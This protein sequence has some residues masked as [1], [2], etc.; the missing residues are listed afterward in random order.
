MRIL[1]A[2]VLAVLAAV[3]LLSAAT[4][5]S[6]QAENEAVSVPGSAPAAATPVDPTIQTLPLSGVATGD[7]QSSPAPE[8][9]RGA[10]GAMALRA[11]SS[12]AVLTARSTTSAFQT[13]GVTWADRDVHPD[14]LIAVRTHASSGWSPWQDLDD[15]AGDD[16]A[17]AATAGGVRGGTDPLWVG[18][19]DGVQARILVTSGAL[20][21]DLKLELVDGGRS[22][23]DAVAASTS[24]GS[25]AAQPG[26]QSGALSA[27]GTLSAS[28]VTEP[29][30]LGRAQWGADD[31]KIKCPATYMPTIKAAV[32]HHTAGKN[33]YS[34]AQVPSI[35]RGDYAYHLSRGWCDIGYNALVDRFG[36]IWEGRAGGLTRAVMGAHAGGFNTDTFGV[37]VI[38]NYDVSRPTPA[39]VQAVARV[40]AWKLDLY[41][42]DPLGTTTLTSA[43]GGTAR[44]KA[45]TTVTLPVIMG[46]RNTGATACPGRYLYPYLPAIR[47]QV[48]ALTKAALMNP[49]GPPAIVKRGTT[50]KITA[51]ALTAQTWRLDVS[52]PCGGGRV[53]RIDGSVK[54]R[55]EITATW[56]G[57]LADGRAARP[58]RYTFTLTSS[59]S[60][61]AARPVSY[62]ALVLPPAP[63][64]EI[65]AAPLVGVGSYL[66]VTP[67][68][69]LDTRAAGQ[70][71]IG[72]AGRIDVP[73]LGRAGVPSS[74]VTAVVLNLTASCGS[75]DTALSVWPSGRAS[76]RPVTS[77]PAG[78]TR[79]VLVTS[80]VGADG[81]IS[82]GNAR[83]VSE[84]TADIVGYYTAAGGWPVQAI[85]SV[86]LYDSSSDPAGKLIADAPRLIP[87]PAQ[88]AGVP[89]AQIKAVVLDVT[90][91]SPAG[92]GTLA[93]YQPGAAGDL[94]SLSYRKGESIDN[95]AIAPVS[96]GSIALKATGTPV[97]ALL[98]VRA[99]IVDPSLAGTSLTALKPALVLDTGVH[100]PVKAGA[101]RKVVLT[102]T[103]TGVPAGARAV[104]IDLTALDPS[105]TTALQVYPWGS[106][107]P[108]GAA[109]RLAA[110]DVRGNLVIVPLGADGAI[111]VS[112]ARGST[113]TRV[114]VHGYLG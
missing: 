79:S 32:M 4:M 96:G 40:M 17:V 44:W 61:G 46:H 39:A 64:P 33:N 85:G 83:G 81:S 63:A 11:L 97:D 98:D 10:P 15:D 105:T 71:G 73:V 67:T 34:A 21:K 78:V 19:S 8:P 31:S 103:A 110:G 99:L 45:G 30:V 111:A 48:Q 62:H 43:G 77:V 1:P 86:R 22:A 91:V 50:V 35:I 75:D 12:P 113:R 69:L 66:P 108:G 80:R 28:S 23:H 27:A 102:G 82:I 14:L 7:P 5:P 3:P 26:A 47:T 90:A 89:V 20:P 53:A 70:I 2:A 87:L 72:P 84:L 24:P 6:A 13:V 114:D 59:S 55:K 57:L 104:L 9:G 36:R 52:A 56:N 76:N 38:G 41:H 29:A 112:N 109:L 58:G 18:P 88:L 74:G 25:Q 16:E 107:A 42:R 92:P 100:A 60:K 106:S 68:R 94:P 51:R 93:A 65:P 95:L 54:A 101:P 49:T 37:S